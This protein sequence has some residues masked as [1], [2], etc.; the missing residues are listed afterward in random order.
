MENSDESFHVYFSFI[1]SLLDIKKY[2]GKRPR[3]PPF[4]SVT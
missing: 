2:V 1:D 3:P 4:D